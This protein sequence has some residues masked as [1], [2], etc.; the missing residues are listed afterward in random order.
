MAD[1]TITAANIIPVA[2]YSAK[3][4]NSAAAITQGQAIYE[5]SSNTWALA[6]ADAASTATTPAVAITE[7]TAANQPV[8]GMTAGDLG[9]GAILTVNEIYV[10]A[11]TAGAI[12][13]IGDLLSGDFLGII[14]VATTTSNLH[15]HPY[16]SGVAKA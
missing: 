12:Q 6:D 8:V 7:A 5:T 4:L 13:P 9:F 16:S 3:T 11:E 10:V 2:G 14:G 1:L 15:L